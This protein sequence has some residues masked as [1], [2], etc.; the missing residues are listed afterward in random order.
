MDGLTAQEMKEIIGSS[1]ED[2]GAVE[3]AAVLGATESPLSGNQFLEALSMGVPEGLA[4]SRKPETFRQLPADHLP[5]FYEF[6]SDDLAPL[7]PEHFFGGIKHDMPGP[8]AKAM[9]TAS[10]ERE[11]EERFE[12]GL[13]VRLKKAAATRN[14]PGVVSLVEKMEAA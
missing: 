4:K 3:D 2:R 1:P 8:T 5:A 14:K 12:T 13:L 10:E 11:L 6:N 9:L 7:T